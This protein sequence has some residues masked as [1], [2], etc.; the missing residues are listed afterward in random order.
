MPKKNDI[1]VWFDEEAQV[2]RFRFTVPLP[3][4]RRGRIIV[5]RD[6]RGRI[7]RTKPPIP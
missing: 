5:E 3:K 1:K 7:I 4:L 6:K 2:L